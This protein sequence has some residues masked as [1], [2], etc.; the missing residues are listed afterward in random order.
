MALSMG[1]R[2][3]RENLTKAL[4]RVRGGETVEITHDGKPV[5]L[6][7]PL[8]ATP[9]ERLIAEGKATLP[10]RPPS[11]LL[12]PPLPSTS[13]ITASQALAEDRGE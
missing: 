9:L 8:P 3:F 2:E 12:E 11:E 4:R 6:V 5:A 10:T 7:I 1:V 13:G